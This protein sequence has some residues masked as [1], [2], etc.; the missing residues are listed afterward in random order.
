MT[1]LQL[2]QGLTD[3]KTYN[4]QLADSTIKE[5]LSIAHLHAIASRAGFTCDAPGTDQQ[6]VDLTIGS[7]EY[8][9][10]SS[11]Y[12]CA[13]IDLQLKSTSSA[14]L[15]NDTLAFRLKLKNY[16]DLRETKRFVPIMLVVQVLHRDPNEW[17]AVDEDSLL[18]K[19]CCYWYSLK[20]LPSIETDQTTIHIPR[21]QVLSPTSL[22]QLMIRASRQEDLTNA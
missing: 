19:H 14:D 22:L 18:L 15:R 1:R 4:Y 7:K 9:D 21:S 11:D 12:S 10:R 20:G 17:L 2:T 6:S 5:Q 8:I 13:K 3:T 16:D